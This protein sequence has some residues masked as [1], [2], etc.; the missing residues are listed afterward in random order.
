MHFNLETSLS[1]WKWWMQVFKWLDSESIS[2]VWF[3]SY[4]IQSVIST[5]FHAALYRKPFWK[6]DILIDYFIAAVSQ[7]LYS[8]SALLF[9]CSIIREA[10][11]R[12]D[13]LIDYFIAAVSQCLY[14]RSA[15]LFSCSIIR[16]AFLKI[17]YINWLFYCC[18]Q[19]M[20]I[21][22]ICVVIFMQHYIG[23]LFE[24]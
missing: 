14:S 2:L 12:L 13:I 16:E 20:F 3:L 24:D 19:S 22:Q 4:G 17:R 6:L 15:L 21:F 7:C 9:S 5:Y 18:C 10:F 1:Y 8:R 23:S 11:W